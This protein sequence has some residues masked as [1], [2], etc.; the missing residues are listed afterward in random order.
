MCNKVAVAL[1][2]GCGLQ[3]S[4]QA[5]VTHNVALN[6]ELD[7][8]TGNYTREMR[9]GVRARNKMKTGGKTEAR[10]IVVADAMWLV[11][12]LLSHFASEN[13]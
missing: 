6:T 5:R 11:G 13:F 10:L 2:A 8:L 4:A 3:T 1:W 9:K 7:T 12:L